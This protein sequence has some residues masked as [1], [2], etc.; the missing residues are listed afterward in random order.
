MKTP[1]ITEVILA[2]MLLL[3]WISVD[4]RLTKLERAFDGVVAEMV[5]E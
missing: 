1:N 5:R 3:T 4:M 2:V